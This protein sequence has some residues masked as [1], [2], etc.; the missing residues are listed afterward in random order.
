MRTVSRVSRLRGFHARSFV[1]RGCA[2]LLVICFLAPFLVHSFSSSRLPP[3]H[4]SVGPAPRPAESCPQLLPPV[5]LDNKSFCTGTCKSDCFPRVRDI[6]FSSNKIKLCH[7]A[8]G[9]PRYGKLGGLGYLP[10]TVDPT[11]PEFMRFHGELLTVRFE[12][13]ECNEGWHWID[14]L[15]AVADQRFLPYKKPNPHHEAEKLIPA[16]LLERKFG[17]TLHWFSTREEVSEWGKGFLLAL[18]MEKKVRYMNLPSREDDSICFHDAI[19]L[20]APTNLLYIPDQSTNQWLRGQVMEYCQLLHENSSWPISKAIVLDRLVGPRRLGNKR[21]IGDLV[22]QRLDVPVEHKLS[23]L[24]SFCE[25]VAPVTQAD[26]FVVPH[27]SQNVVMLFARPGAI[28]IEVFPHLFHTTALR[29]FT[30]AAEVN[31]YSVLGLLPPGDWKLW[32]FSMFGWNFCYYH[33]RLCKNY[34]RRQPIYA[35]LLELERVL[36]VIQ[37]ANGSFA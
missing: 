28:I 14:G 5:S 29:N 23:G 19:L 30:H 37:R 18:G 22:S 16:V 1:L 11:L 26:L 17:P 13:A 7:G 34:A 9:R 10:N 31:V 27:G 36:G 6:C 24:G 2:V 33:M 32:F 15:A 4:Y 25:Q 3:R 8:I 21:Q 35:D 20:S 12:Y